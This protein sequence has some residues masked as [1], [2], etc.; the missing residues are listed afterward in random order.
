MFSA[1]ANP[2]HRPSDE[3]I[4]DRLLSD[5]PA[6]RAAWAA[7]FIDA[8]GYF[9]V[10]GRL[11]ARRPVIEVGQVGCRA[12]L[13]LL[14]QTLGG[15]IRRRT[16]R[17]DLWRLEGRAAISE[18]VPQIVDHL[19]VKRQEALA[20]RDFALA[21][22]PRGSRGLPRTLTQRE[23]SLR[24]DAETSL[25]DAKTSA[26]ISAP[27]FPVLSEASHTDVAWAAGFVDGE[28]YLGTGGRG[29][30]PLLEV[31]QRATDAPLRRLQALFGGS[32]FRA[33]RSPRWVWKVNSAPQMRIALALLLPH[34]MVKAEQAEALLGYA[35]TF[36][37]RGATATDEVTRA[38]RSQ[39]ADRLTAA[40]KGRRQWLP[41]I[42]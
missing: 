11:N 12:A 35:S 10:M 36:N 26:P 23:R 5:D 18:A 28:G 14:E 21:M 34:L 4:L 39:L 13:V 24:F 6:L 31:S 38:L 20:V 29:A 15:Q 2:L 9:G 37:A 33:G 40:R 1:A 30:S 22:R 16:A 32:L 27:M 7:G 19:T 8:E 3:A 25:R 41:S 42:A 17:V